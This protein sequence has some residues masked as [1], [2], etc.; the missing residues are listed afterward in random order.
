MIL[1]CLGKTSCERGLRMLGA[2]GLEPLRINKHRS[3][4]KLWVRIGEPSLRRR[5]VPCPK[6]IQPRL[7]ISFL[8]REPNPL[9]IR[10]CRIAPC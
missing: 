2:P 9:P 3:L 4:E 8:P 10:Y 5:H 6:V 7:R 1:R